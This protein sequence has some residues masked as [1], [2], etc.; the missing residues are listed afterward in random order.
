MYLKKLHVGKYYLEEI[1]SFM[2]TLKDPI[3]AKARELIN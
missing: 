2:A 3:F 1:T